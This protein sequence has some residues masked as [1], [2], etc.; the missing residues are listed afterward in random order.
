MKNKNRVRD[1]IFGGF[2][3]I[4]MGVVTIVLEKAYFSINPI[5]TLEK[6]PVAFWAVVFLEIIG[7]IY[8]LYVGMRKRGE[9]R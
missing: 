4:L 1:F 6:T 5:I 7:G 9:R 8:L 3:L 2:V